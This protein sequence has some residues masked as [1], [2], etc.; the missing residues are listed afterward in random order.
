MK[1]IVA[2]VLFFTLLPAYGHLGDEE[3]I[4]GAIYLKLN[5]IERELRG[6]QYDY[7]VENQINLLQWQAHV[8]KRASDLIRA[9]YLCCDGCK[10]YCNWLTSEF[11][12]VGYYATAESRCDYIKSQK[13][14]L[15]YKKTGVL[16]DVYSINSNKP[17]NKA[18]N[19]AKSLFSW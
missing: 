11:Q 18:K 12:N 14:W 4:N 8:H 2:L 9:G 6:N 17:V 10:D 13:E 19:F 1:Y 15:V 3:L 16:P 7:S 5:D